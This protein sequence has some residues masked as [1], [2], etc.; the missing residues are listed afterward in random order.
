MS[1]LV[2]DLLYRVQIRA[3][4]FV[5]LRADI[6]YATEQLKKISVDNRKGASIYQGPR[7]RRTRNPE[8]SGFG[9]RSGVIV[10]LFIVLMTT[11]PHLFVILL[12]K[13]SSE[14]YYSLFSKHQRCNIEMVNTIT[15]ERLIAPGVYLLRIM[16]PEETR[17]LAVLP[18]RR[19]VCCKK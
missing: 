16:I 7:Q 1:H 9:S 11:K 10:G 4:T 8:L 14:N 13:V 2:F 5:L 19:V 15:P 6:T 18:I 3:V 12:K 17:D